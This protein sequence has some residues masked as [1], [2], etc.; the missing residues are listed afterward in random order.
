MSVSTGEKNATE[1]WKENDEGKSMTISSL[2]VGAQQ[3]LKVDN[4]VNKDIKWGNRVRGL[5]WYNYSGN[6]WIK[7]I[8]LFK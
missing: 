1:R 6:H 4:S 3:I 7:N 8:H 5:K 2:I